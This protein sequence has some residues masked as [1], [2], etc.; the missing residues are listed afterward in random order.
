MNGLDILFTFE[1]PFQWFPGNNNKS[2]T[3]TN[4]TNNS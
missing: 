1:S 3:N 2:N 4:V